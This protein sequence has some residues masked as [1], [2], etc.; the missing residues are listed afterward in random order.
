MNKLKLTMTTDLAKRYHTKKFKRSL[1]ALYQK[2]LL[3]EFRI[4]L[5][6]DALHKIPVIITLWEMSKESTKGTT[7]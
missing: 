4:C 2:K 7:K 1:S 5:Q 3:H 6:Y